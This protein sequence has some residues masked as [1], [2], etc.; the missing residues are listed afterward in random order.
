MNYT[1]TNNNIKKFYQ[2]KLDKIYFDD[3]YHIH[4]MIKNLC[5]S[6]DINSFLKY[7]KSDNIN[8]LCLINEYLENKLQIM[9]FTKIYKYDYNRNIYA[10]YYEYN[11]KKTMNNI[12][13]CL[14]YIKKIK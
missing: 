2:N 9:I 4:N 1:K 3:N 7:I 11:V 12:K 14:K 5:D 13:L 10:Y 6:I 8:L